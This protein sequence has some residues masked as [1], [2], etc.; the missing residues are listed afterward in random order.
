M[1]EGRQVGTASQDFYLPYMYSQSYVAFAS[2]LDRSGELKKL[3]KAE[4]SDNF[5]K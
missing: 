3:L 1:I 2:K 5:L 4:P